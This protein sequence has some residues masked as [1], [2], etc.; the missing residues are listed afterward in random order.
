MFGMECF[1]L[2]LVFFHKA[3]LVSF[4][5]VFCFIKDKGGDNR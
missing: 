1:F 4:V 2:Y 3:S 5:D